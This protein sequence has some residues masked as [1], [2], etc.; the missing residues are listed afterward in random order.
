MASHRFQDHAM[1]YA[2]RALGALPTGIVRTLAGA[3][4]VIDG[5]E[6]DPTVQV[7]LRVMNAAPGAKFEEM[8]LDEARA[9]I[10]L[11]AWTF[12]ST[13]AVSVIQDITIPTRDGSVAARVYRPGSASERRGALVYFHGGGWVVG[14][15]DSTDAVCRTL[16]RETGMTIVSVAYRLAPEHPFPAGVH[17]CIDAFR[18]VRDHARDFDAS[19]AQVAVGGESA[20]GNVAA[21]TSLVTRDDAAGAP[22]GQLLFCPV[23][24]LSRKA[25]SYAL[26]RDGFFL[27]EA[28]MDWYSAHY[29]SGGGSAED[30]MVSPLLAADLAGVAPAYVAVSGFDVLRDE[31][32]AYAE[33]LRDAGVPTELVNHTAQIHGF[34]NACGVT[35]DARAALAHAGA[36]VRRMLP[37]DT[38]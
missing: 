3:P 20:G 36:W 23:T 33:R 8:P 32:I 13:Q 5:N 15:L 22:F 25:D 31:G 38:T 17:D 4:V 7:S 12:A 2:A 1:R 16:A 6:L 9:S 34:V 10:D 37:V 11:E 24:D 21:V 29:L 18:W 26:F 27:T 19:P 14:S 30:P 35:R 28:Q